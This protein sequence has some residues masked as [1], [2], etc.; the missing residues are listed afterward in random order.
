MS[1]KDDTR[2][3][4]ISIS[5]EKLKNLLVGLRP[6]PVLKSLHVD[7][8]TVSL[9]QILRELHAA[10]DAVIV[11]D[12]SSDKPYDDGLSLRESERNANG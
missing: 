2:V 1:V 4:L 6:M 7:G 5:I 10:M 11:P 9:A 8:R 12:E 3:L